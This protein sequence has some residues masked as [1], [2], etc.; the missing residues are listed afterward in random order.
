MSGTRIFEALPT[1]VNILILNL[2]D[3]RYLLLSKRVCKK[4]RNFIEGVM[5]TLVDIFYKR[6]YGIEGLKDVFFEF[7]RIEM[8]NYV[9]S[10]GNIYLLVTPGQGAIIKVI[11]DI[12]DIDRVVLTTVKPA[13]KTRI[14]SLLISAAA[15]KKPKSDV[16]VMCKSSR[17]SKII[18]SS[19][20][21]VIPATLLK[22]ENGNSFT[23]LNRS[24]ISMI[25]SINETPIGIDFIGIF[26]VDYSQED[27]RFLCR[28]FS[29]STLFGISAET[30]QLQDN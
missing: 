3:W 27:W 12:K 15:C 19:I 1:D 9:F 29:T 20:K 11:R 21:N 28:R 10:Y 7:K 24:H 23:L 17:Y 2:V 5:N 22:H 14:F 16:L 30:I 6:D 8:T 13:T 25:H 26:V 4:W 18:R